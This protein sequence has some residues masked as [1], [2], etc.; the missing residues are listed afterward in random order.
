LVD[1]VR[2]RNRKD[3]CG[4]RLDRVKVFIGDQECGSISGRSNGAWYTVKC[5]KPLFGNKVR[6]VMVQN[7][8][9]SISGI[10]VWTAAAQV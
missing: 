4:N 7:E 9:L 10:E 1:R 2:V 3:C 5:S 6:L 8:Y